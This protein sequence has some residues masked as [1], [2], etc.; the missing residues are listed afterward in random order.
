MHEPGGGVIQQLGMAWR[1]RANTEI[2]RST[3]QSAT[4]MFEPDTIDNDARGQRIVFASDG[5]GDF[6]TAAPFLEGF[7]FIF[8]D[9]FKEV[10]R[11]FRAL[12][13]RIAADEDM[14]NGWGA[15]V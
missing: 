4:K 7:A 10:P 9:Q 12:V 5:F 2:A 3:D 14:G 8:L 11:D 15:V 13:V 6:Q 1:I